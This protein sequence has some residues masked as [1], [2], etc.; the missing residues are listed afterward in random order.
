MSTPGLIPDGANWVDAYGRT[1]TANGD[2]MLLWAYPE[3]V[4]L[5]DNPQKITQGSAYQEAGATAS[6]VTGADLSG[7]IVIDASGLDVNVPGSYLVAYTVL[8]SEGYETK[9]NRTVVVLD[10]DRPDVR[11]HTAQLLDDGLPGGVYVYRTPD[12]QVKA[13][14]VAIGTME[15]AVDRMNSLDAVS[16]N[17]DIQLMVPRGKPGYSVFTLETISIKVAQLLLAGNY[18][19]EGF[20]SEGMVTVGG[21]ELLAGTLSVMYKEMR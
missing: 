2:D 4:L 17:I 13:P 18:R 9:V 3:I 20:T 7:S 14:A 11:D 19:V 15:W 10:V 16:W 1:W 12:E 5:G 21:V 6:D 8:D